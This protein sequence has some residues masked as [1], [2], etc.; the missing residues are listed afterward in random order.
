MKN[1]GTLRLNIRD[2]FHTQ[3]YSGYSTFENSDEPFGLKLDS[4]VVRLTFSWR[5]GKAMK[6]IKRS[7]GGATEETD[8]VGPET[9][10]ERLENQYQRAFHRL[11]TIVA[12]K[13][14]SS[15]TY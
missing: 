13:S 5:F 9:R 7:G 1:K 8:R 6:A 10:A 4:R 2:M 14:F 3:N 12:K 15:G 11:S